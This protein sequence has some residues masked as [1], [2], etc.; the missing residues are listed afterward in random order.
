MTTDITTM[1][2]EEFEK[3]NLDS[4]E[5]EIETEVDTEK[6]EEEQQEE[7]ETEVQNPENEEEELTEQLEEEEEEE[8]AEEQ[9]NVEEVVEEEENVEQPVDKSQDKKEKQ[10]KLKPQAEEFYNVLT[11]PIKAG[12][13]EITIRTPEEAVKLI[14]K[15]VDYSNKMAQLASARANQE[16]LK[17]HGLDDPQK[18]SFLIDVSKGKPEAIQ[19]LI[20][21]LDID[22]ID[23]DAYS[24][25]TYK[26]T[27]YAP[28]VEEQQ[29]KDRIQRFKQENENGSEVIN[30]LINSNDWDNESLDQV[31]I[32][33]T[34]LPTILAHRNMGVYD[35]VV[36]EVARRRLLS[37]IPSGTRQLDAY[38]AVLVEMDSQGAFANLNIQGHQQ[39]GSKPIASGPRVQPKTTSNVAKVTQPKR[40]RNVAKPTLDYST[41]SDEE[42]L[43]LPAPV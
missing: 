4:L 41:M 36:N 25:S 28:S 10:P 1:S 7:Q 20:Q 33:E 30:S 40:T 42:F 11:S 23:I 2:D 15:G 39:Q 18:L 8:P 34:I 37:Q 3:L 19:K 14:Q 27:N 38:N 29:I 24:E 32:D 26:P 35:M 16:M 6:E 5:E 9:E 31:A 12:G 21:D 43:K 17:Q 22:P 13:K